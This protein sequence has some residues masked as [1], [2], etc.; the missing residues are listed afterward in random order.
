[1]IIG[2]TRRHGF[3]SRTTSDVVVGVLLMFDGELDLA[4]VVGSSMLNVSISSV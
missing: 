1:M 3:V 2:G 4:S